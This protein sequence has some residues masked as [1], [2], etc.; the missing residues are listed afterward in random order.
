MLIEK[1]FSSSN[2]AYNGLLNQ[3]ITLSSHTSYDEYGSTQFGTAVS[4]NAR[5]QLKRE[6]IK[7]END[8]VVELLG[9]VF[10]PATATIAIN[11]KLSFNG[12]DYKVVNIEPKIVGNGST[13]HLEV[14]ITKWQT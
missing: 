4:Y 12:I 8:Q 10:L 1:E 5:V 14:D 6:E 9:R 13:H 2:M 11:D 7:L 3:T